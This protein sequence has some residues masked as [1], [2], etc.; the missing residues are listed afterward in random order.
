LSREELTPTS[1]LVLALVGREGAGPHD[2]ATMLRRSGRLYWHAAESKYYTEPKRLEDLGFLRS[3]KEP[4]KT[5]P[6]THY[7]L[8][9]KGLRALRRYLA[10]PAR[11]PRMQNEAALRL[12]AADLTDDRKTIASLRG[13]LAH[14]DELEAELAE[15]ERASEGIPHRARYLALSHRLPRKLLEAH[16]EWASEVIEEL[17]SG[18]PKSAARS[19][20]HGTV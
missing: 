2:I 3:T 10:L 7:R 8:T 9:A 16:R 14:L 1:F 15:V 6:R 13:L 19:G 11:F 17:E 18:R 5:K 20:K 4:G 12:L